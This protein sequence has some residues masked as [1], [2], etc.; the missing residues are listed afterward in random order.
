MN[1][2]QSQPLTLQSVGVG[3]DP[4]LLQQY[5]CSNLLVIKQV[6]FATSL[7]IIYEKLRIERSRKCAYGMSAIAECSGESDNPKGIPSDRISGLGR[8]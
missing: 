8:G 7:K 5:Y 2:S 6:I 3:S 1:W 4:L